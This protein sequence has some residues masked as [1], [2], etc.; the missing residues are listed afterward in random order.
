MRYL[1]S[2]NV[3][4]KKGVKMAK[5]EFK[6]IS[7]DDFELRYTNKN[8]EEIVKP[9]K[10]TVA[11]ASKLQNTEADARIKMFEYLVEKGKTKENFIIEKKDENGKIVRDETYYR[12]FESHFILE[13]QLKTIREIYQTLFGMTM[14]QL[15]EDIGFDNG[16]D[17]FIFGTKLR[18]L[19]ING[20]CEDKTPSEVENECV[21]TKES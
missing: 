21:P 11:L 7:L 3:G 9:F 17:T 18:E 15:I 2:I 5:Y 13:A 16:N 20:K 10:R 8:N 12:E 19:L 6:M 4:T 1:V 14:E